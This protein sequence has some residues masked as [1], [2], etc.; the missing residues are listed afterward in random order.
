MQVYTFL[1]G[2]LETVAASAR[3]MEEAGYDAATVG[4]TAHDPFLPLALAASV[5]SRIKLGTT[6][7]I[8]FPRSPMVTANISWDLQKYAKGR[9]ELGLGTQVKG[10]NVRRFSVPWGPPLPRMR[11]YVES[12]RAIWDCWQNNTPLR[13]HG[14]HYNFSLMTPMF[15]PGPIE[16]PR[17]PVLLAAATP[18]M[19]R[20]TGAVADGVLLHPLS[21]PKYLR[22]VM[23]PAIREGAQKAGRS[24][25]GFGI[26]GATFIATGRDAAEVNAQREVIRRRISFYGSTRTYKVV[27]DTHGWGDT[28][29]KLFQMSLK[30]QTGGG[31]GV[32][33]EMTRL[34]TDEMVDEFS[35][36]A[37]YEK[38]ASAIREKLTGVVTRLAVPLPLGTDEDLARAKCIVSELKAG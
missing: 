37:T 14:E 34:V 4:E 5:T 10:H 15:N 24:M 9:F 32:W 6:V 3:R 33:Q 28:A 11:E 26:I 21:T 29:E 27:M 31:E 19:G 8:A 35:V 2:P 25:E 17:I 18:T 36:S 38:L 20:M 30:G 1:S 22:E 7:A 16:H 12:V 23:L 13:Y